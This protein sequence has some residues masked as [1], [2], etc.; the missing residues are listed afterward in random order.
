ML[1]L[2]M[3]GLLVNLPVVDTIYP[4]SDNFATDVKIEATGESNLN[5]S[6]A[7]LSYY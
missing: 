4:Q 7:G 3:F 5:D 6:P 1:Q 2:N